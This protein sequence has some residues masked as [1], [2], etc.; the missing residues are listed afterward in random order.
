MAG[1]KFSLKVKKMVAATKVSEIVSGVKVVIQ[2]ADGLWLSLKKDVDVSDFARSHGDLPV[3]VADFDPQFVAYKCPALQAR[4]A[5]I[6]HWMD[7]DAAQHGA[8]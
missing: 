8:D 7:I 3:E 4:V 5:A 2:T 6:S 1:S